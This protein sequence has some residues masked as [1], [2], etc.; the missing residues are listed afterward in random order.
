MLTEV[1]LLVNPS[2]CAP[3]QLYPL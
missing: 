2:M 3:N 1:L